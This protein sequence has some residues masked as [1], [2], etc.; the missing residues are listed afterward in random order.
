MNKKTRAFIFW[1]LV[2]AMCYH[3]IETNH[4]QNW[5]NYLALIAQAGVLGYSLRKTLETFKQ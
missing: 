3:E 5:I 2:A 4:L 1:M